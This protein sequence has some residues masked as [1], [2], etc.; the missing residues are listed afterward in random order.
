MAKRRNDTEEHD[1]A[2]KAFKFR[3]YPNQ[4]QAV[5][6]SKTFGCVR[7]VYNRWLDRKIKQY[8]EDKTTVTYTMCA[9]EMAELKN[10]EGYT[11][12]KEVDSI[13]L[14]QALRHLDT[15]FQNFFHLPQT[16]FPR[17]KSKKSNRNRRPSL[18]AS[19]L[20]RRIRRLRCAHTDSRRQGG[21]FHETSE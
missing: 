16:G 17:F 4:E 7:F 5:M 8:E 9:G 13:A 11:F 6:L 20:Y 15:A 18:H 3:L 21:H 12:L 2:N 1:M 19:A 10:E 14:Q